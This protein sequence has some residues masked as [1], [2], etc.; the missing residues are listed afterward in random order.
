MTQPRWLSDDEQRAWRGY[1][2]MRVLLDLQLSRDLSADTGLS[3]ADYD[4]LSTLTEVPG[5]ACRVTELA[6]RLHWQVSRLSHHL[7]RMEA[8]GLVVRENCES[9]ARGSSVRLTPDGMRTIETAAPGHVESVRRHLI[10][11][12]TPDQIQV[13]G[14][15]TDTVN[16]HFATDGT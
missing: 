2:R 7:K 3:D 13:L 1:R 10:D 12:L 14:E 11:L 5:S 6:A 8:R 4:V 9:D 15:I 16:T